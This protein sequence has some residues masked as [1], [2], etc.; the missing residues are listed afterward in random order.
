MTSRWP[1]FLWIFQK[2]YI[3]NISSKSRERQRLRNFWRTVY[4]IQGNGYN[5]HFFIRILI[6]CWAMF[7]SIHW[8]KSVQIRTRNNSVF[9]HF[10]SSDSVDKTYVL[11]VKVELI[12]L[13]FLN[14][15]Y[16]NFFQ[17]QVQKIEKILFKSPCYC[18]NQPL[19]KL[20]CIFCLM[21]A[22]QSGKV[23]FFLQ[24]LAPNDSAFA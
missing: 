6:L 13:L 12:W 4:T 7:W 16:F 20:H 14:I 2:N 3:N 8:V 1:A 22:V 10:S 23:P 19:S 9:G 24:L 5:Y 17:H 11:V 21:C 15:L 18:S